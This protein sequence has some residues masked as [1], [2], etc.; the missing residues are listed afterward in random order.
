LVSENP[1][2]EK[3]RS[4]SNLRKTLAPANLD[5][6]QGEEKLGLYH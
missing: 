5:F 2:F 6:Y 1:G 3:S 4:A